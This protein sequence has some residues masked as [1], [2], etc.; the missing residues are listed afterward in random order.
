MYKLVIYGVVKLYGI[1]P[2]WS[3]M[4]NGSHKTFSTLA[5]GRVDKALHFVVKIPTPVR[6]PT[7]AMFNRL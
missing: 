5:E 7:R 2:P 1:G 4:P 6:I 3:S